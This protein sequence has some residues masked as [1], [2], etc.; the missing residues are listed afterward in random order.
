M[1]ENEA[2]E[3]LIIPPSNTIIEPNAMMIKFLTAHIADC[4]VL[5]AGWLVNFA[6]WA[7]IVLL[8]HDL[9]VRVHPL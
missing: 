9:V 2:Q 3:P 5:G 8:K 4:A 7:Y 1:Q 6:C